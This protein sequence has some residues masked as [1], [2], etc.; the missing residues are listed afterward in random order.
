MKKIKVNV[1][2]RIKEMIKTGSTTWMIQEETGVSSSTIQKC[3]N[4]L[5]KEGYSVGYDIWPK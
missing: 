1:I 3:R 4:E 5:K 2:E